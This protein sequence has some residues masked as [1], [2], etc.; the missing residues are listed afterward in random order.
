MKKSNY[1]WILMSVL[2]VSAL[3]LGACKPSGTPT[4]SPEE[5]A[6]QVAN[7]QMARA[8]EMAVAT[9][10]M[11]VTELSRPTATPMPTATPLPTPTPKPTV[12]TTATTETPGTQTTTAPV[13]GNPVDESPKVWAIDGKCYFQ[14]QYLGDVNY[15]PD[16]VVNAGTSFTKTWRVK[17]TG[18]CTWDNGDHNVDLWF[19]GGDQM[20]NTSPQDIYDGAVNPGDTVEVS[21]KLFAPATPGTYISYWLPIGDGNLR[22][23]YGDKNQYSLAVKIISN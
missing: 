23:G 9:L 16:S 7:T 18:T 19:E 22:F 1:W 3:V 10:V 17:N 8:T 20:S 4:P 11:R 5:L 6:Q 2:M 14:M 13:T 12:A 21:V 15:P